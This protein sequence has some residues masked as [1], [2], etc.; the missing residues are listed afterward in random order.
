MP[1]V[2]EK[3][4]NCAFYLY[5]SEGDAKQ[6]V[7]LGG[8]GFVV[9]IP[10]P[11]FPNQWIYC[12]AITNAH[13]SCNNP[14]IRLNTLDG[15]TDIFPLDPSDWIS[16]HD[17]F[18]IAATPL[19]LD[20]SRHRVASI[21]ISLLAARDHL[22]TNGIGAGDDVFMVGRFVDHDGGQ[23]NMPALRFGNISVM[24]SPIFHDYSRKKVES[25]CIDLHSRTGYSGS[26]VFVYQTPGS[27]IG[28]ALKGALTLSSAKL[29]FLGI[30]WGQF[31]ERW[32]IKEGMKFPAEA[33]AVSTD[34]QFI[35]GMSGMSLVDPSWEVREL[36]NYPHFQAA[37]DES[38]K[39]L[40]TRLKE[41]AS[42]PESESPHH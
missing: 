2:P 25:Y 38:E 17:G 9:S 11:S 30:H 31:P 32:E 16:H 27:D 15:G 12:Y 39:T 40:P 33:T 6:G 22:S 28:E 29:F 20:S 14:V 8:T 4:L 35:R 13:V 34:G 7:N 21:D 23:T 1:R 24:P 5:A 42:L 37:R 10:S 3:I 41:H 19:L 18:D 26:P 36:L